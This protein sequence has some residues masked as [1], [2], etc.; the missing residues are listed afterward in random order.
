MFSYEKPENG[1]LE[2]WRKSVFECNTVAH[3]VCVR[4]YDTEMEEIRYQIICADPA[5]DGLYSPISISLHYQLDILQ[6]T[7]WLKRKHARLILGVY[8]FSALFRKYHVARHRCS[9]P[10]VQG[11]DFKYW[12]RLETLN[13]T[14]AQRAIDAQDWVLLSYINQE[15]TFH[16]ICYF[17]DPDAYSDANFINNKRSNKYNPYQV[18]VLQ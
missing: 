9:D 17:H 14:Y 11:R 10:T 16:T 3:P 18:Y 8:E 6:G 1:K 13:D 15:A 2:W 4:Y 5:W 7:G 12:G